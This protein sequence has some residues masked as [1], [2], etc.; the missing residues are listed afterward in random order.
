M[1]KMSDEQVA[2]VLDRAVA[3][4]NPVLEALAQRD[5]LGL[6]RHT[7]HE[8]EHTDSRLQRVLHLLA[9]GLDVTDWPGTLGWTQRSM[10]SRADWWISRIGTINTV[11]VAYPGVFGGWTRRL[12][13]ASLLGFAN[14]AI[15]LVAIARE[16]GVTDRGHQV[17]LLASVLCGRDV[18]AAVVD[19][20]AEDLEP[21]QREGTTLIGAIWDIAKIMRGLSD[22]FDRRPQPLL[23]L[24]ML[25]YIPV[26]GAPVTY[27]GERLALSQ[28]TRRGR[29]WIAD[30]PAAVSRRP[31]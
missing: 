3:G 11:A 9:Q 14:Q 21:D 20:D 23:P 1:A 13:L 31:S 17:Q 28:A 12:P 8:D 27:I 25:A 22:E 26:V 4:I 6:K 2:A 16:Y 19:G 18:P 10:N 15:V 29:R 7:F 24:R 30:H 5:P